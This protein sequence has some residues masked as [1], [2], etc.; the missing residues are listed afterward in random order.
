MTAI[1]ECLDCEPGQFCGHFGHTNT[2]GPCS[3]GYYCT[4]GANTSTPTDGLTGDICPAGFYCEEGS[5]TPTA[6]G[7]GTYMNHTGASAC[8]ICPEGYFCVNRDQ[9]DICRQGYYCPEGTGADL[10]PCPLGTF[11]NTTG[12]GQVDECTPC[13]GG[14]Y[15]GTPGSPDPDGMCDPGYYCSAGVDI[16]TPTGDPMVNNGT[17]GL[18]FEG[19]FCPRGTAYPQPC[20][21]GTFSL[22]TGTVISFL[23][24]LTPNL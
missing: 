19:H 22:T 11:G 7:N 23:I 24:V 8:Y 4:R 2:T 17:G 15:C 12:L 14:Y 6:C 20:A 10:Q 21:A 13:T 9:A 16:A 5:H 18:C 3:S 1:E